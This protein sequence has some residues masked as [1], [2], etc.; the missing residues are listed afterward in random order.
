MGAFAEFERAL[1]GE[2]QREGI[3][4][5]KTRGAY[6]G[7]RKTLSPDQASE[8]RKRAGA[9]EQKTS[10]ASEFGISRETLCQYLKTES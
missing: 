3:T 2:R 1:I 9:G 8:L 7:H 6:R 5:A 4:L 10:R